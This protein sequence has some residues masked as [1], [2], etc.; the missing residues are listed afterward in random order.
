MKDSILDFTNFISVE[1]DESPIVTED[2]NVIKCVFFH[3]VFVLSD[4]SVF[5]PFYN[6]SNSNSSVAFNSV[7]IP[8]S[9]FFDIT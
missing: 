4:Q 1:S 7:K 5:P 6:Q 3:S 8:V 9:L 2:A